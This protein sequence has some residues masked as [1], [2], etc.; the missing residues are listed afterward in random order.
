MCLISKKQEIWDTSTPKPMPLPGER[1]PTTKNSRRSQVSS[2]SVVQSAHAQ[3]LPLHSRRMPTPRHTGTCSPRL[4]APG[5]VAIRRRGW[6]HK[7][8]WRLLRE[9]AV[10]LFQQLQVPLVL[11]LERFA[12]YL[13]SVPQLA[14]PAFH[15]LH[16]CIMIAVSGA[17]GRRLRLRRVHL[18]GRMVAQLVWVRD[19]RHCSPSSFALHLLEP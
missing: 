8:R 10:L 6:S 14:L 17:L 3:V 15:F 19:G 4:A 11:V 12:A 1:Y 16:S 9:V 13:I 7:S 5:C 18:A 2:T